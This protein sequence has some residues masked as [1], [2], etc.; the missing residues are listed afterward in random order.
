M[1]IASN[2]ENIFRS[3]TQ[4]QHLNKTVAFYKRDTRLII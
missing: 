2:M 4:I 3:K 1:P